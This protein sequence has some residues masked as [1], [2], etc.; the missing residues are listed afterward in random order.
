MVDFKSMGL[1]QAKDQ[2]NEQALREKTREAILKILNAMGEDAVEQS[3]KKQ[4]VAEV[5]DEALG[6]GP[7][8]VLLADPK[9]TEI[10]INGKDHIYVE[11]RG[12][13]KRTPLRFSSEDQLS[14]VIER[15]VAPIGRR[16]DESTP[17]VDARLRDGSRVNIIIPPLSLVGP[18]VT[19]RRFSQTPLQ[20]SDLVGFGSLSEG[21]A[22]FLRAAI[23]ARLNIVVSGGTGSGKTTLLNVLSS[24][25][26]NDQRIV[27]IEDAAELRL[28]QEHV[29]SLESRPPNIEG[30]GDIPIRT[31][32][33]NALR[34]R[35]DRIV[36][37]ECRGGE[38]L[39]MLQAMN[40]GHDGSLTTVHANTP[41][42]CVSRLE[43]LVMYAGVQ[44]PSKA[45]RGQIA[46]AIDMIVQLNRLSDG[47]R[48]ITKISEI[49]GMEGDVI[50]LQDIFVFNQEK[51]DADKKVIGKHA[52]TGVVPRFV[53][54]LRQRGIELSRKYFQI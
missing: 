50:T 30:K 10:M 32:L 11:E 48:R 17:L 42:D 28:G 6:L 52:P 51:V 41:R 3:K 27:T 40:T 24:F 1:E 20:V 21:M 36:I 22:E 2:K 44:L 33:K 9:L 5:L 13:L 49:T 39:D 47:S 12:K 19:I 46:A 8:E 31:L 37:G 15:I 45:I 38:A 7:L 14:A 43:T 35:P 29:I 34:M 54:T 25:I 53:E 26:G 4:L 16:I 18:V 23:E